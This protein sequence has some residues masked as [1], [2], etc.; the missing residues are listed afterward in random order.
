[1]RTNDTL[2]SLF[3]SDGFNLPGKDNKVPGPPRPIDGESEAIARQPALICRAVASSI[4]QRDKGTNVTIINDWC[5]LF[6]HGLFCDTGVVDV[7]SRGGGGG[8]GGGG[9]RGRR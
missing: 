5:L 4:Q 1:M 3:E 6:F 7:L 2:T 9:G 8:G